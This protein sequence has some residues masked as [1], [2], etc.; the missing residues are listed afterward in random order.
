MNKVRGKKKNIPFAFAAYL[1]RSVTN[2]L[3]CEDQA[4]LL[5]HRRNTHLQ[6]REWNWNI[7][8]TFYKQKFICFLSKLCSNLKCLCDIHAGQHISWKTVWH[9]KLCETGHGETLT[10]SIWGDCVEFN[11]QGKV[12]F[13]VVLKGMSVPSAPIKEPFPTEDRAIRQV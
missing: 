5:L 10:C 6:K 13:S 4:L 12:G 2:V 9:M 11:C 8:K 7:C 3:I 1:F